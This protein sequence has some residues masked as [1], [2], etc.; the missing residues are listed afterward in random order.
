M[1]ET[2]NVDSDVN[3]DWQKF[4]GAQKEKDIS[5]L[6]RE[7]KLKDEET[8]KIIDNSF[9]DGVFKTIDTDIDRLMP[10]VSRFGGGGNRDVKKKNIIEKLMSFFDKYFGLFNLNDDT[11]N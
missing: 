2:I 7:E 5:Y 3:K 1:I 6:I 11:D 9:R 10:T 8:R 4:V